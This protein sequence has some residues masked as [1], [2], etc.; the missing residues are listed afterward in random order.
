[1]ILWGRQNNFIFLTRNGLLVIETHIE[2]LNHRFGVRAKGNMNAFVTLRDVSILGKNTVQIKKIQ[3]VRNVQAN[4]GLQYVVSE[5]SHFNFIDMALRAELKTGR[6]D[7]TMMTLAKF[8]RITDLL[9]HSQPCVIIN[10]MVAYLG[11]S[12]Y[13]LC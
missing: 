2:A 4:S 12:V 11:G 9:L 13:R 7:I 6:T 5:I 8:P 3:L 10:M 1:M